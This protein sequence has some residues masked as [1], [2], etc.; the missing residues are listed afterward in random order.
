M[1]V[2]SGPKEQLDRA[3]AP[4][5][6]SAELTSLAESEHSFV[7]T[8]VARHEHTP[9]QVLESLVPEESTAPY[10][11]PLQDLHEAL[12]S[13]LATRP[14]TLA[15]LAGRL[16]SHLGDRDSHRLFVAGLHLVRRPDTPLEALGLLLT[17]ADT[18]VQFRKVAAREARDRM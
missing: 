12:A 18:P 11:G 5:T 17:D 6:G 1:R 8:A 13:N 2:P 14:S 3:K 15:A 9:P 7:R 4:S 16:Q 10:T